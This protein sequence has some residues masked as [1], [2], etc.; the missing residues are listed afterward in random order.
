MKNDRLRQ[1]F[2]NSV[3]KVFLA[4]PIDVLCANIVKFGLRE[5]GEIVRCLPDK[6]TKVHLALQLSL[7]RGSRPKSARASPR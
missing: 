5:I 3:P 4:L 2:Q 7:L 6:K 1:N